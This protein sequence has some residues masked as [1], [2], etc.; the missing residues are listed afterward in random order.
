MCPVRDALVI[1]WMLAAVLTYYLVGKGHGI[2]PMLL[3]Y[4]ILTVVVTFWYAV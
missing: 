1:L 3:M 2:T 4:T